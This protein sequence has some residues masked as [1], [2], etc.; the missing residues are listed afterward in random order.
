[1]MT[2]R[3]LAALFFIVLCGYFSFFFPLVANL[4]FPNIAVLLR[5]LRAGLGLFP[6]G[7]SSWAE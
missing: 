4:Q 5:S 6:R 1:M 2:R 7:L 3:L